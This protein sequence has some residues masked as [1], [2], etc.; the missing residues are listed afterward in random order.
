[1]KRNKRRAGFFER[2]AGKATRATGSTPAIIISFSVILAWA[3]CGPIFN[4][5]N[6]WQ[7]VINTG[8]TIVTFMMVFLIQKSQN[9]DSVAVHLKLDELLAANDSTSSRMVDVEDLTEDELIVL[10]KYYGRLKDKAEKNKSFLTSQSIDELEK[11]KKLL[12]GESTKKKNSKKPKKQKDNL[13]R[14]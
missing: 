5:S 1:M 6:T 3:L 12:K 8:T 13:N 7:L 9:K 11:R 14:K 2:L 4:Y 10:R